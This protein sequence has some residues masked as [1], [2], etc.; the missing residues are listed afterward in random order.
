MTNPLV[1]TLFLPP[2]VNTLDNLENYTHT[3]H[4][5]HTQH[6][7]T[8][9]HPFKKTKT[10]AQFTKSQRRI[11]KTVVSKRTNPNLQQWQNSH[12]CV[13]VF[14]KPWTLSVF[15]LLSFTWLE[16]CFTRGILHRSDISSSTVQDDT[17]NWKAVVNCSGWC[18]SHPSQHCPDFG[19]VLSY[20]LPPC[21]ESSSSQEKQTKTKQKRRLRHIFPD[22]ELPLNSPVWCEELP[23]KL[24]QRV[25]M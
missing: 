6:T 9:K 20:W 14:I 22:E 16:L 1:P 4:T 23:R 10:N 13:I 2:L 11:L 17:V 8:H 3:A 18:T 12:R 5:C 25:G 19:L 15:F 21:T 24:T 7:L